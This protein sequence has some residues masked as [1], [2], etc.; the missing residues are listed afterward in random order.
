MNSLSVRSIVRDR[1]FH[2]GEVF[3]RKN[4]YGLPK[5]PNGNSLRAKLNY[6]QKRFKPYSRITWTKDQKIP[7]QKS[8]VPPALAFYNH[9]LHMLHLGN[10]NDD[11][12][13][14]VYDGVNWTPNVKIGQKSFASPALAVYKDRLHMVH[15][16][17]SAP[18]IWHSNYDG[19]SWTPNMK[20][21]QKSQAP[22]SLAVYK[23]KLHIVHLGKG[24]NDIWHSVYDGNSW[25]P[26]SKIGL[27]STASPTLSVYQG[28]LHMV[29]NWLAT[30]WHAIYDDHSW[31]KNQVPADKHGSLSSPSLSQYN[32]KLHL[33]YLDATINNTDRRYGIIWHTTYDGI[34]WKERI[35][36]HDQYSRA[37]PSIAEAGGVLYMSHL[38]RHDNE[39]WFSSFS[40]IQ[41]KIHAS[42]N[43]DE[44]VRKFAPEVRFHSAEYLPSSVPW[45]LDQVELRYEEKRT[46]LP[47]EGMPLNIETLVGEYENGEPSGSIDDMITKFALW[48]S[49]E[50]VRKGESLGGNGRSNAVCYAHVRPA[51]TSAAIDIQ[52]WFFYPHN[53]Q[54]G[55]GYGHHEGDWEHITVRVNERADTILGI[56]FGR[57]GGEGGWESFETNGIH[58]VVYSANT[59]HASYP[60][61]G[62]YGRGLFKPVDRAEGKGGY[63]YCW[64]HVINVGEKYW[65]LNG[66]TWLL[67]T[68]RW[69]ES[70]GASIP[71]HGKEGESPRTPSLKH[72]WHD[73]GGG[74]LAWFTDG[75]QPVCRKFDSQAIK[76]VQTQ[77]GWLVLEG[78]GGAL[79]WAGSKKIANR[80]AMIIRFYR[81]NE[82]CKLPGTD[83][84]YLLVNGK[85]PEGH[86]PGNLLAEDCLPIKPST[87][88]VKFLNGQWL[89]ISE[90]AGSIWNFNDV[91]SAMSALRLI[92]EHGFGF[93]CY[94]ERPNP[95]FTF[96][97]K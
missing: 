94:V 25:T 35:E 28:K 52:Y 36:V 66:Q 67:F 1:F 72:R 50:T 62:T 46:I 27:Q 13:H 49:N 93:I 20:I 51:P 85:A 11:I 55:A 84:S 42:I 61:A 15:L 58:P 3:L 43:V 17:K 88:F 29:F 86:V 10:E 56:Y 82:L 5:A 54:E 59:S 8:K 26:N 39:I 76:V 40:E 6:L 68:G 7:D 16:G 63:W 95:A 69:G 34:S 90:I 87:L 12:W 21:D 64:Q 97:R 74:P 2:T 65:P 9:R 77:N 33:V 31:T 71:F 4:I 89:I 81:V 14:S 44:I 32:R 19:S 75:P 23:D 38:G 96:W 92:Q 79:V 73:D 91:Q 60:K 83:F 47:K 48:I 53:P 70:S 37:T 45:L 41:A 80:A 18:D 30:I 22:A 57:H 24:S 78:S